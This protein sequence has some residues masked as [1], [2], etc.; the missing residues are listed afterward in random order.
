M[1]VNC[2]SHAHRGICTHYTDHKLAMPCDNNRAKEIILHEA[3]SP[4]IL[5][6]FLLLVSYIFPPS[7][8]QSSQDYGDMYMCVQGS[9]VTN[10]SLLNGRHGTSHFR[11]Y[12][13]AVGSYPES[14]DW[15]T[16]GAVTSV[17]DQV[18]REG[19][20]ERGRERERVVVA[21][22]LKSISQVPVP[23]HEKVATEP[24]LC[25][26]CHGTSLLTEHFGE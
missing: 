24:P 12:A 19:G 18:E 1:H 2:I 9:H 14:V 21:I 25:V 26:E 4:L 6:S 8:P 17:K 5:I 3:Y 7:F 15:R 22:A 20:R 11:D 16:A 23:N 10:A 13:R